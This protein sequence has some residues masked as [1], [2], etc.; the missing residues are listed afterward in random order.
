[1]SRDRSLASRVATGTAANAVGQA[2]VLISL[3]ALTPIIVH[4][5]GAGDYGVWV[6]IGS[7]ASL[8]FLAEVGLSAALI[9][10]VADHAARGEV[11]EAAKVVGAASWLYVTLGALTAAG[12]ATAALVLPALIELHGAFGRLVQPV[13]TLTALDVGISVLAIAPLAVLRGLQRFAVVNA[14]NAAGALLGAALTIAVLAVGGGIGGV[15]AVGAVNSAL[16]YGVSLVV[17]RRLVPEFMAGPIRRDRLRIRRLLKFSRSIAVIQVAVQMQTKLDAV[18]IAAA[19]PIRFI[20][21]YNFAQRLAAGTAIATDQFGKVLLPLATEFGVTRDAAAL[22]RLW[23]RATRLTL[24]IALAAGLP[25]AFLGGPVLAIWVGHAFSH[26]GSVVTLLALAA[27]VDLPSNPAAYV[28]QS[29]ER[30]G[31]MAWMA[32]GSGVANL[33]LSIAFVGPFG[34][35]GVA[36]GTLLASSVEIIVFVLPYTARMLGVTP[37]EFAVEVGGRLALPAA[38]LCGLLLG[39]RAIAPVTTFLRLVL[40]VGVG[41]AAY[42]LIYVSFCAE[43]FERAAYRRAAVAVL[44]QLKRMRRS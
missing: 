3:I 31:P 38:A 32:L 9:K 1:M 13:G 19:L 4:A 16:T 40:V 12:G 39:A 28:L 7:V 25:L 34:I 18:V 6:L 30:H 8:G 20:A 36:T 42:G 27:I 26:D 41:L 29:I 15:A 17:A 35:D 5:V 37:R 44:G 24:A 14:I 21:P 10:F 23:L 33:A 2:V 11:D 22:R 43:P